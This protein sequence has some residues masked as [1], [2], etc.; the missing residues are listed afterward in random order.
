MIEDEMRKHVRVGLNFVKGLRQEVGEK[1]VAERERQVP[2]QA[3]EI[4]S[5]ASLT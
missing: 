3:S 1:I 5:A 4:L 2:T